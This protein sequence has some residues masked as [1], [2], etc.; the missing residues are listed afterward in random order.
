M[1]STFGHLLNKTITIYLDDM[2]VFFQRRKK[3]LKDLREVLQRCR[4]HGVSLN[5]KKSILCVTEGKLL[6]HLVSKEGIR[7]DLE[8]VKAIQ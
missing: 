5:P 2:T 3:H 4:D 1:N 6:G 8:R 7:V